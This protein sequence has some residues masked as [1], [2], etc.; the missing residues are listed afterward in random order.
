MRN[1][2]RALFG[3]KRE[4][5]QDK[6]NTTENEREP[7]E[8]A[9]KK[10][11][12]EILQVHETAHEDVVQA[13]YRRLSLLYHP[14]RNPS[15]EAPELM[16]ELNQAYGVLSDPQQRDE[17]DRNRK[18]T[19]PLL[20]DSVD[21]FPDGNWVF[22]ETEDRLSRERGVYVTTMD[23]DDSG[24]LSVRIDQDQFRLQVG[25]AEEV[26][27]DEDVVVQFRIDHSEIQSG[28]W[29]VTT[30]GKSVFAPAETAGDIVEQLRSASEFVLRA[31]PEYGPTLTVSFDLRGFPAAYQKLLQAYRRR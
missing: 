16:S 26:T 9:P 18:A 23:L 30:S 3:K 2:G 20:S 14:D 31:V 4:E 5:A 25:F 8:H 28:I 13:A 7:M 1:I 22:G 19:D 21:P 15:P 11:L 29:D 27:L 12:Y 17:Y 24:I 6:K 10:D